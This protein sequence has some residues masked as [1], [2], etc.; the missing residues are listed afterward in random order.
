MK[1]YG[2][3]WTWENINITLVKEQL[4]VRNMR[5]YQHYTSKT[6]A[7][8]KKGYGCKWTRETIS[9]TLV[10]EQVV[11]RNMRDYQHYSSKQQLVIRKDVDVNEHERLSTLH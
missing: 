9:I 7:C 4:V 11:V 2:C 5:D 3:K 8:S 10:K 6:T 1:W